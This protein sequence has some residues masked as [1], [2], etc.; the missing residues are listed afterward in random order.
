MMLYWEA[1]QSCLE[2]GM[3]TLFGYSV[4]L[5]AFEFSQA[6]RSEWPGILGW[7]IPPEFTVDEGQQHHRYSWPHF[8][9]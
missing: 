3:E 2:W 5:A 7:G 8:H 6:M 4:F 1:T 9:C